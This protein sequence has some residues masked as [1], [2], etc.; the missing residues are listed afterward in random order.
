MGAGECI[1]QNKIVVEDWQEGTR[2]G[3]GSLL[4]QKNSKVEG[5]Y[6]KSKEGSGRH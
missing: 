3:S 2:W 5:G 4:R 1:R 6:S